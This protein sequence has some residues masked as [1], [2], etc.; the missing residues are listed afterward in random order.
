MDGQIISPEAGAQPRSVPS[1]VRSDQME[2][3]LVQGW[4][5]CKGDFFSPQPTS[6]SLAFVDFSSF[7][8]GFSCL[9]VCSAVLP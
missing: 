1:P 9:L 4:L 6:P 7:I 5:I 3:C 2:L 8:H